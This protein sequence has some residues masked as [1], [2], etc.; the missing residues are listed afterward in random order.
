[1]EEELKKLYLNLKNSILEKLK[2]FEKIRS[3][4]TDK[5]LFIEMVF[6]LLTP[7]SSALL[8]WETVNRLKEE[9]LIFKGNWKELSNVVHPVRFKNNK[10]KCIVEAR[11]F[12]KNGFSIKKK[13]SEFSDD[14]QRRD[15]LV[16][17]IKGYGFKEASHFLRNTG[18]GRNLAILDRHILKN[19]KK[20]GIIKEIPSS[21]SKKKYF[22]IEIDIQNWSKDLGIPI[23][24]MDYILWYKETRV[25][26]K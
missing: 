9:N 17:N 18:F 26:F 20:N 21:L 24:Y 19:L 11:K 10:A 13:L 8:C 3:Y 7:Q 15:W 23:D 16:S 5:D 25:I 22:E 12:L 4:G 14:Y 1:M 6:C 2:E